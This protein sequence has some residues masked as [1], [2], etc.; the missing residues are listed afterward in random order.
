MP[1]VQRAVIAGA[2]IS[3]LAT[4]LALHRRGLEAVVLERAPALHEIGAGIALWP[5]ATRA[6]RALGALEDVAR[7]SGPA[8]RVRI[9]DSQGRTLLRFTTSRPDA[10]SLCVRRR[11]LVRVLEAALPAGTVRYDSGL[12]TAAA[13]AGG[14]RVETATG[15]LEADVLIGADGLRSRVR[16]LLVEDVAPVSQR[17]VAWRGVTTWP[18]LEGDAVEM[19]GDGL[20]FGLFRL[21]GE[22][23]YWYALAT[24]DQDDPA[25]PDE[26]ERLFRGWAPF[27]LETVWRCV[28]KVAVHHVFD[29]PRGRWVSGPVVL[30]GDAAHGMTPDLGQGGAQGL[31][32]AV[33]LARHLDQ[34]SSVEAALD[35][36]RRERSRR[37]AWLQ[38][39]SRIA[40]RLGQLG[41]SAGRLRNAVAQVTPSRAFEAGFTA[42]F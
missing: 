13:T 7:R 25:A 1:A 32:D 22:A 8:E 2:G 11:D 27:V 37:A 41:G 28:G 40:G 31:E 39:Q 42:A 15:D 16:T 12:R 3:G 38:R 9:L 29:R 36:Y 34:A 14:V 10:P 21:D 17:C 5:N 6:L 4:A 30:V 23:A 35:G 33:A 19:W 20:R 26:P 24:R 18:D